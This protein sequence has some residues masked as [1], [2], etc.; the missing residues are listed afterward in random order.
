M[1]NDQLVQQYITLANRYGWW[2]LNALAWRFTHRH[3]TEVL[4]LVRNAHHVRSLFRHH[5][6]A[7]INEW[8]RG[9]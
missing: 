9:Q 6:L 5:S 8:Y 2:S 7:A 1:N 3:N 4:G